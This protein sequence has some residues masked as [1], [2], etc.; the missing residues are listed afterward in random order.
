M[1]VATTYLSMILAATCCR[2]ADS[3]DSAVP[4]VLYGNYLIVVRCSLAGTPDLT[5]VLDTGVTETV[6]D[7]ALVERLS[8]PVQKTEDE[9]LFLNHPSRVE[10]VLVSSLRLGPIEVGNL[11]GIAA[12]LS[13][14]TR[15][16]GFRPNLIIGMNVLKRQKFVIDYRKRKVLFGA[17]GTCDGM[18]NIG[19]SKVAGVDAVVMGKKLHLQVDSE[20]S[21]LLIYGKRLGP[22]SGNRH[23]D[24]M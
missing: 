10:N 20:L 21:S 23:A 2:A 15:E 17:A 11:H 8:L 13:N 9:A 3:A 22:V 18:R 5:A 6:L 24:A 1:K 14:S 4:F 12:D 16:M 7:R 19:N